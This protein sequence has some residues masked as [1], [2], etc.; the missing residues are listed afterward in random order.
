MAS[1]SLQEKK[2]LLKMAAP[3]LTRPRDMVL[4]RLN[5]GVAQTETASGFSV[6]CHRQKHSLFLTYR[7][8]AE[9]RY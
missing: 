4:E 1:Y 2:P 6:F 3:G 7:S 8:D 9:C 5:K